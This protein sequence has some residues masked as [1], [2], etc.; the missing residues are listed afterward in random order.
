M[1]LNMLKYRKLVRSGSMG[2]VTVSENGRLAIKNSEG[3][4]CKE[5]NREKILLSTIG[6]HPNIIKSI[7]LQFDEDCKLGL[8]VI[9]PILLNMRTKNYYYESNH[10]KISIQEEH[11][12]NIL[13]DISSAIVFLKEKN[14]LH[15]DIKPENIGAKQTSTGRVIYVLFDFGVASKANVCL[16]KVEGTLLYFSPFHIM[17]FML[18][19]KMCQ[20]FFNTCASCKPHRICKK[21]GKFMGTSDKYS[22]VWALFMTWSCLYLS[23]LKHH[24]IFMPNHIYKRSSPRFNP[25]KGSEEMGVFNNY[26]VGLFSLAFYETFF[27]PKSE[28]HFTQE[29]ANMIVELYGVK[30]KLLSKAIWYSFVCIPYRDR[31]Y[32][33][34]DSFLTSTSERIFPEY[35][36]E[37]IMEQVKVNEYNKKIWLKTVG[38]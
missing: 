22:D 29:R 8:E 25:N 9:N 12:N 13:F 27:N 19:E 11:A 21:E 30:H 4:L 17:S 10:E 35:K 31:Y 38:Q 14:I 33:L 28:N 24:D 37:V 32:D 36:D 23:G 3:E 34:M 5:L 26:N 18:D 20:T 7:K 15:N 6:E 16:E 2:T 1:I